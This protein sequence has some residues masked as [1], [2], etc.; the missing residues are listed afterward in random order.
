M[1]RPR[2]PRSRGPPVRAAPPFARSPVSVRFTVG[3]RVVHRWWGANDERYG[4]HE[5]RAQHAAPLPLNGQFLAV[6]GTEPWWPGERGGRG[7]S[8]LRPYGGRGRS[9]ENDA[10]RWG[11]EVPDGGR[12]RRTLRPTPGVVR[13]HAMDGRNL[14]RPDPWTNGTP[15]RWAV[16][17][18]RGVNRLA[19]ALALDFLFPLGM[20]VSH[21]RCLPWLLLPSLREGHPPGCRRSRDQWAAR[22]RTR[23]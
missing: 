7:R 19:L 9:S 1:L 5:T 2:P 22:A 12:R 6:D 16:G 3:H 14:R 8:T 15:I 23:G 18:R 4:A 11:P 17:G 13:C 20:P 10:A 21:V